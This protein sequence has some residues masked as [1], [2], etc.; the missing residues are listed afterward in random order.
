MKT[1][2]KL[3]QKKIKKKNLLKNIKLKK[4]KKRNIFNYEKR[5][6]KSYISKPKSKV[7]VKYTHYFKSYS[8]FCHSFFLIYIMKHF[9]Y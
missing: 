9:K 5:F 2:K 4:E 8:C 7:K 3:K 1:K 6:V